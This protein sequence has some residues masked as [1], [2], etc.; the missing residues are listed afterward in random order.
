MPDRLE[1]G[2][3]LRAIA[4]LM[5]LGCR[6][7]A[8]IGTDHGYIPVSLLLEGRLDEVV[9]ELTDEM[10]LAA[11][12]LRFDTIDNL[13]WAKGFCDIIVTAAGQSKYFVNIIIL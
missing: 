4:E 6:T 10:E 2:P 3:R 12:E 8:D 1:L 9:G 13:P 7:L 11:A 5:P